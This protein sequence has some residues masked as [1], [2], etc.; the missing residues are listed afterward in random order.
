MG[1]GWTNNE[2]LAE[3]SALSSAD[4]LLLAVGEGVALDVS[5]GTGV[6]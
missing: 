3:G 5:V 1:V 4:A 2:G 6:L